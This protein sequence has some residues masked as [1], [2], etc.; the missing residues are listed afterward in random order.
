MKASPRSAFLRCW[1]LPLAALSLPCPRRLLAVGLLT[2]FAT[3]RSVAQPAPVLLAP[4]VVGG[5]FKAFVVTTPGGL[6]VLE[7]T[8]KAVGDLWRPRVATIGNGDVRSL[9]DP[10]LAGPQRFYRVVR[11]PVDTQVQ[12]IF[13]TDDRIDAY[14]E[15]NP[16]RIRLA[17]GVCAL[18]QASQ[19]VRADDGKGWLLAT[20]PW[21]ERNPDGLA[22]PPCPMSVSPTSRG[23]R[24]ARASWS[25][26]TSS[27]PLVIVSWGRG[28]GT[29]RA[30][31]R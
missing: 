12:P 11:H 20:A 22:L 18:V 24:S 16:Q 2:L 21:R 7:S 3:T 17:D 30:P 9:S 15:T 1:S 5:E 4:S 19:L 8:E 26:R 13:G 14:Q 28:R 10:Q 31:N 29:T 6:Y 25:P 23:P 27:S